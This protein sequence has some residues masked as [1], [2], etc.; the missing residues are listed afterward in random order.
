MKW[1]PNAKGDIQTIL[2]PSDTPA[3]ATKHQ[4]FPTAV[5]V[6]ISVGGALFLTVSI[7]CLWRAE[8]DCILM[9]VTQVFVSCIIIIRQ[10]HQKLKVM[11]SPDLKIKSST[12]SFEHPMS[13][14]SAFTFKSELDARDT[15]QLSPELAAAP[16]RGTTLRVE[17]FH[18][19]PE[20]IHEMPAREPVGSEV[21]GSPVEVMLQQTIDS[22]LEQHYR[23]R[24][25]EKQAQAR[26][27]GRNLTV[28]QRGR[29]RENAIGAPVDSC[30]RYG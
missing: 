9:N 11:S 17:A 16:F 21:I 25:Q 29:R 15:Q 6:A 5:I 27:A 20:E 19:E 26:A 4:K 13:P 14:H 22:I 3:Q 2:P 8:D 7:I 18:E 10:R 1:D 24:M 12:Q 30:V 23:E 28:E